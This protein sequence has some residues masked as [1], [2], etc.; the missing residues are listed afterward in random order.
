MIESLSSDIKSLEGA[1]L[2]S[3]LLV[4]ATG[5]VGI[6]S[7]ARRAGLAALA[8]F[9][10]KETLVYWTTACL[11]GLYALMGSVCLGACRFADL[12]MTGG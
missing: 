4:L 5:F 8:S 10:T 3:C 7:C 6:V 12:I 1:C 2:I 11:V 9:P